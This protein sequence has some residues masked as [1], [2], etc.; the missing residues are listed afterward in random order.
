M[1]KDSRRELTKEWNEIVQNYPRFARA[2]LFEQV[3]LMQASILGYKM[4]D[5][6]MSKLSKTG[7]PVLFQ[8]FWL[9][10]KEKLTH[11]QVVFDG[12]L[13]C[14][15]ELNR[16]PLR[17]FPPLNDMFEDPLAGGKVLPP[18]PPDP[19]YRPLV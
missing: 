10:Q 18:R 6:S 13:G 11:D 12:L 15:A 1:K 7:L 16:D 3:V 9:G 14:L 8:D 17:C 5:Q 4:V 2:F 19:H